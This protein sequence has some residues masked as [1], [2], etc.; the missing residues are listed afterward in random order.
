MLKQ[1]LI[2]SLLLTFALCQPVLRIYGESDCPDTLGFIKNQLSR[3]LNHPLKAKLVSDIQYVWYGNASETPDSTI[4]NRHFTCQHGPSECLGNMYFNCLL[5]LQYVYDMN[6][7]HDFTQCI[8]PKAL[9]NLHKNDFDS[10]F[11]QCSPHNTDYQLIKYCVSTVG[12]ELLHGAG[13]ITPTH[14]FIPWFELDSKG[15]ETQTMSIFSDV[16][17]ALCEYNKISKD[18]GCK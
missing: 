14:S 10:L 18:D 17:K 5:G 4:G 16:I 11:K 3:L 2:L 13:A 9:D 6:Y 1:T 12:P 15:E 8:A 7:I